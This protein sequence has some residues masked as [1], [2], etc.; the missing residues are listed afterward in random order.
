MSAEMVKCKLNGEFEIILPKHRA[1]RPDWYTD[2]GWEKPRLKALHKE[3]KRQVKAGM[4]PVVYYVGAEEGEMPALCQMWGARVVMFEPNPLVLPNIKAIWDA[5]KLELPYGFFVGFASNETD[6]DPT[7]RDPLAVG[8]VK[9]WPTAAFGDVIGDHGFKELY[10]QADAFP[11]VKMD[12]VME[13]YELDPPTIIS[14]DCE[15]SEWQVM[16]GAG[17]ILERFKPVIFASI[18]PEFMFHQWD[19]YSRDFR[20]WIMDRGYD[21]KLLEYLHELHCVYTPREA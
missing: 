12:D 9:E 19:Q 21:E 18:S 1:D 20:N 11:Q 2:E 6:L 15:G 13:M 16:K 10:Q 4:N 14:F 7:N 3:I 8:F 17:S 5:N